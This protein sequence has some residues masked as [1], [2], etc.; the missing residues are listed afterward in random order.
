MLSY[1][2]CLV[3]SAKLLLIHLLTRWT[4]PVSFPFRSTH[5]QL[6]APQLP[7]ICNVTPSTSSIIYDI[8]TRYES[9]SRSLNQPSLV[10]QISPR[11]AVTT[12]NQYPNRF[13]SSF[14]LD[15]AVTPVPSRNT[16]VRR[17]SLP[18]YLPR[19]AVTTNNQYLKLRTWPR[20]DPGAAA[21]HQSPPSLVNQLSRRMLRRRVKSAGTSRIIS[22]LVEGTSGSSQPPPVPLGY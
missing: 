15:P 19:L 8:V 2:K 12:N 16:R 3:W 21:K 11:L 6:L 17:L 13:A 22:A 9:S 5:C 7:Q 14:A 20:S 18:K 1:T 10:T 4:H